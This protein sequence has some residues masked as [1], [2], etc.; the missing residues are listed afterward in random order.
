MNDFQVVLGTDIDAQVS[1]VGGRGMRFW[2]SASTDGNV[3]FFVSSPLNKLVAASKSSMDYLAQTYI[4]CDVFEA[5]RLCNSV[6][7][8][9]AVISVQYRLQVY[10]DDWRTERVKRIFGSS[11]YAS[12]I[13][14]TTTEHL[15]LPPQREPEKQDR[16]GVIYEA[17]HADG[18]PLAS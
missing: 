14:E 1:H 2:R 16:L 9:N 11:R 18:K 8:G 13:V 5:M 4:T 7:K 10:G 12:T 15:N 6:P 3:I 17:L